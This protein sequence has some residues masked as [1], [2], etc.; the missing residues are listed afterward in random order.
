MDV[1]PTV[2]R[3]HRNGRGIRAAVYPGEFALD[4]SSCADR[5]LA[6]QRPLKRKG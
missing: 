4:L 5:V 1:L 6:P 3:E 2:L